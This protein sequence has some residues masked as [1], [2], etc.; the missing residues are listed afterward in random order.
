MLKNR[1]PAV[2]RCAKCSQ[3]PSLHEDENGD[4]VVVG[5]MTSTAARAE[6]A[7]TIASDEDTVTLPR[8]LLLR[9]IATELTP[10]MMTEVSA[11]G[12]EWLAADEAARAT[13]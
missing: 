1:T 9:F 12:A 10:E 4:F 2:L 7:A 13:A 8:E 6:L 11:Y 5:K 3:C